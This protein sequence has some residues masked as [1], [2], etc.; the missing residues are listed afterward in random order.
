MNIQKRQARA[1]RKA[2]ANRMQRWAHGVP[3]GRHHSPKGERVISRGA[4]S[5]NAEADMRQLVLAG[6]ESEAA[7][8]YELHNRIRGASRLRWGHA[9][10]A[11]YNQTVA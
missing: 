11:Q 5:I 10:Y 1:K 8:L 9:W 3:R 6:K 7:K 4:G 2:K